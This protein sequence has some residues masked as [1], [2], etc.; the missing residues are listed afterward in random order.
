MNPVVQGKAGQIWDF[1]HPECVTRLR[2][3][4]V[5]LQVWRL[6]QSLSYAKDHEG[7]LRSLSLQ[8]RF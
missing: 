2:F 1:L 6:L 4:G 7:C 8:E 5:P 3:C